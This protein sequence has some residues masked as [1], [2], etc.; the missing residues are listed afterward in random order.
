M[1]E[2]NKSCNNCTNMHYSTY[3][4]MCT[5]LDCKNCDKWQPNRE[6]ELELENAALKRELEQAKE[7]VCSLLGFKGDSDGL[8]RRLEE[9]S[10]AQQE[11]VWT[12]EE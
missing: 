11:S 7:L 1:S 10:A 6:A 9:L 2:I 8:R 3:E 5:D 12:R 4:G